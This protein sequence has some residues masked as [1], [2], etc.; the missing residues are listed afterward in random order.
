MADSEYEEE[1]DLSCSSSSYNEQDIH[2]ND[3][4]SYLKVDSAAIVDY[5]I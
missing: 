1:I 2:S 5:P 3:S 4:N